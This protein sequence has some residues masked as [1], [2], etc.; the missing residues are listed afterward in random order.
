MF[1]ALNTRKTSMAVQVTEANSTYCEGGPTASAS[2]RVHAR[3]GKRG[4]EITSAPQP[5]PLPVQEGRGTST[6]QR[7][8]RITFQRPAVIGCL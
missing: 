5:A 7:W 6:R 1:R 3:L 8:Q 4:Q 2:Y